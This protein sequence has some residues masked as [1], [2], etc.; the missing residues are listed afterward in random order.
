[1]LLGLSPSFSCNSYIHPSSF[2][3]MSCIRILSLGPVSPQFMSCPASGF[4]TLQPR[5]TW[6]PR[7]DD[8]IKCLGN[9]KFLKAAFRLLGEKE[10]SF[11]S[12]RIHF[13]CIADFICQSNHKALQWT[14]HYK[15][16][17]VGKNFP[18]PGGT[19]LVFKFMKVLRAITPYRMAQCCLATLKVIWW[20]IG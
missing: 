20:S 3:L 19:K 4:Y 13:C 10:T 2:M 8:P 17:K 6:M 16:R 18:I 1:M 14:C 15:K 5:Q 11:I 9:C 12:S 7:Q